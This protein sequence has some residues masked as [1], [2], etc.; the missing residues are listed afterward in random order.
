MRYEHIVDILTYI[1]IS[2]H[3]LVNIPLK[4]L[5]LCRNTLYIRWISWISYKNRVSCFFG[6]IQDIH[7]IYKV[8]LRIH[9]FFQSIY[10]VLNYRVQ[11][12]IS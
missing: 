1:R 7:G 10:Y 9:K 8:F 3:K 2:L 11:G 4:N 5:Y 6:Y 12:S